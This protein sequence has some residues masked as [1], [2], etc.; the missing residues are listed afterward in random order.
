MSMTRT[1]VHRLPVR[2]STRVT[3]R[4]W[5]AV[6]WL[7]RHPG[8]VLVPALLGGA[9]VRWGAVPVGSAVGGLVLGLVVWARLHPP[10]FDRWLA[11]WLRSQWR[12][13]TA[14]RGRRW[15]GVLA[16]CE[17]A[18]EHRRTG[19]LVVPRVL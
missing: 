10:S 15:A 4:E 14:Y 17:L 16:D 1:R 2:R 12:R 18:C 19:K 11:P 13:W 7:L 3:G 8:F 6:L 9:A 5:R